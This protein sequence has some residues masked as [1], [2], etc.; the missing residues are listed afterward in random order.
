MHTT[1]LIYIVDDFKTK[2]YPFRKPVRYQSVDPLLD[3]LKIE[4]FKWLRKPV[5][6]C[7]GDALY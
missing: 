6:V 3:K 1:R 5:A 4:S 2:E 7:K